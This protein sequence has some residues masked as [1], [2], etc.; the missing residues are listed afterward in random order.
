MLG[1]LATYL[2]MCGYDTQYAL[3]DDLEADAAIR[4]RAEASGRT[5]VTR[6]R[7]LA[8]STEGVLLLTDREIKGQ[9][10]ELREQ[11]VD[12]DLPSEP[13]RC[14]VCNGRVDAVDGEQPEHTP[15][16]IR[17]W[18]CRDC[19]QYFWKGSYGGQV[20]ATIDGISG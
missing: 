13:E 15:D 1:K 11:G 9:L 4:E 2:R 20:Q 10:A 7:D 14:S 5:L 17:I 18:Q 16:G 3:D 19:G 12:I 6:D 8:A